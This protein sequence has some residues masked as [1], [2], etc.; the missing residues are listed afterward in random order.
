MAA[1][2][3]AAKVVKEV[4]VMVH[5]ATSIRFAAGRLAGC[6]FVVCAAGVVGQ[7]LSQ[8][9]TN[10]HAIGACEIKDA[11]ERIGQLDFAH[12]TLRQVIV[13]EALAIAFHRFTDFAVDQREL[14]AEAVGIVGDRLAIFVM[15][16]ASGAC[17]AVAHSRKSAGCLVASC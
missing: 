4:V 15:P 13:F 6:G 16:P 3:R 11:N 1:L 17:R 5:A 2:E 10:V 8:C 9:A 14:V 12:V 7:L